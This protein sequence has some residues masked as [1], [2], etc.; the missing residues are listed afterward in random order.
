MEALQFALI[1]DESSKNLSMPDLES[2]IQ[3]VLAIVPGRTLE[4]ANVALHDN[5]FNVATAVSA[6]LDND[7]GMGTVSGVVC[8]RG[9]EGGATATLHGGHVFTL[10]C[11]VVDVWE[12]CG[13]MYAT[14]VGSREGSAFHDSRL[15]G[16]SVL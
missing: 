14:C 7:S 10:M 8:G 12:T 13:H 9:R 6:L 16:R 15:G 2:R 11:L 5:D 4:E 3:Q 1:L